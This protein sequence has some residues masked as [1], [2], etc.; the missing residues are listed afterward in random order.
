MVNI[1]RDDFDFLK[2]Y[3]YE[4][5]NNNYNDTKFIINKSNFLRLYIPVP[6][7]YNDIISEVR[8]N[9]WPW[10]TNVEVEENRIHS[11]PYN[12]DSIILNGGYKQYHYELLNSSDSLSHNHF[13]LGINMLDG[14][15]HGEF[16][17]FD[18]DGKQLY[19]KDEVFLSKFDI[20]Q[21]QNNIIH[22]VV[23]FD[24][25]TVTLNVVYKDPQ[26]IC[27]TFNVFIPIENEP[28]IIIEEPILSDEE[29]IMYLETVIS[30]LD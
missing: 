14:E 9:F 19:V 29:S 24:D 4:H 16:L 21:Y 30:Y 17:K 18:Q 2:S 10:D 8:I 1:N 22:D 12:F 15:T 13:V 11:H 6:E 27:P 25:E 23:W 20:V 5:L 3:A 28:D 26:L 7:G